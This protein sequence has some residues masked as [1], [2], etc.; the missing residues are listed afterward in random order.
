MRDGLNGDGGRRGHAGAKQQLVDVEAI[1]RLRR[2]PAGRGVRV[3]HQPAPL[4]LGQVVPHGR[5]RDRERAALDERL[6]P[7]RLPR[8]HVFLDDT[9]QKLLLPLA[10]R[11]SH[12]RRM[13]EPRSVEQAR[14][15]PAAEKAATRSERQRAFA[16][17]GE[18]V[19][20]EANDLRRVEGLGD[21]VQG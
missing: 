18:P 1:A 5:G 3:H 11:F 16:A 17:D 7:D 8:R 15:Y 20:L 6:R 21:P 12:L 4:E 2:H 13:V 9:L 14:S 19:V 10:Q